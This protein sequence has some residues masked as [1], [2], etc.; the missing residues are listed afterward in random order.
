M[1]QVGS[2]FMQK[3]K[4]VTKKFN[5]LFSLLEIPVPQI[6]SDEQFLSLPFHTDIMSKSHEYVWMNC[7]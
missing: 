7:F 1:R 2:T 3:A 6:W 5:I 4:N